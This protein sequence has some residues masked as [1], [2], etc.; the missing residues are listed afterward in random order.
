[1]AL[2]IK[3]IEYYTITVSDHS[4]D[5]SRMLSL[6]ADAGVDLLAFKAAPLARSGTQFTLFPR[7]GSKLTEGTRKAGLKLEGPRS[8]LLIKGGEEPGALAK[9]YEKLAQAGIQVRESSGIADIN[10][11]YGVILYLR[12]EDCDRAAVALET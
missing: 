10:G 9:I 1:M 5:G 2:E 11:G 8:A 12:Q 7:D 3:K 6:C 4:G